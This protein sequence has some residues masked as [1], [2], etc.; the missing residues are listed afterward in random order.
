MKLYKFSAA[1]AIASG[2][3]MTSCD[4]IADT[5]EDRYI[6]VDRVESSRNVLIMEFTGQRCMN[7]PEGAAAV[8]Q[9]ISVYGEHIIPMSL[10]PENTIFTNPYG[11][12][13]SLLTSQL[14]TEYYR[15]YQSPS[16]FPC[17]VFDGQMTANSNNY[18]K[19][20][21]D[22]K[23]ALAKGAPAEL[24][25]YA[26]LSNDSRQ[27]VVNYDAKF[28]Y[29]YTEPL[30]IVVW[31]VE[32]G[33]VAPQ[34]TAN[35]SVNRQYVNN[36]VLRTSF[37]GTWGEPLGEGSNYQK[38]HSYTGTVNG[39]LDESWVPENCNII[40]AL[41]RPDNKQVQQSAESHIF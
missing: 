6:P 27:V 15:Y 3:F 5:P 8:Q 10:H 30:N 4:N 36:H 9:M 32:S 29:D 17:A 22:A 41:I 14:A 16:S 21:D 31:V 18:K 33:I 13:P 2:F 26:Q 24:T 19:W 23:V 7:C 38:D 20:E 39:L 28:S 35:G 34:Q 40:V 25:V 11:G 37:N 12:G 1:L